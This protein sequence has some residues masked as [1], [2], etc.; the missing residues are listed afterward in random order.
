[1]ILYSDEVGFAPLQH[2]TRKTQAV[3]W[4]FAEFG[5]SMLSCEKV[6]FIMAGI[7]SDLIVDLEDGMSHLFKKLLHF[8][9]DDNG[10]H[11]TRAG[12][13]LQLPRDAYSPEVMMTVI[14]FAKLSII[15]SDEKALKDTF[16]C[17]GASGAKPCMECTNATAI[18]SE[19]SD[20]SEFA[21]AVNHLELA[22]FKPATDASVL[23]SVRRV[24]KAHD[25]HAAGII[26]KAKYEM[27]Q[28]IHGYSYARHNMLLDAS[29]AIGAI[30]V[31]M[32]DWMHVYLVSGMF[33]VEVFQLWTFLQ[34]FGES[35][36]K[37][38]TFFQQWTWPRTVKGC[39]N[40]F[41][42]KN[43]TE[44]KNTDHFKTSA[45]GSLGAYAVIALY[46]QRFVVRTGH[47][48]AQVASFLLLCDVL[49]LCQSL[50]NCTVTADL[51]SH[52][53][54]KHLRAYAAAYGALGFRFK[55]HMAMHLAGQLRR[56]GFLLSCF[57]QERRHKAIKR[58]VNDR[59][60]TLSFESG[61][62]EEVTI[63][64]LYD[65]RKDPG[66]AEMEEPRTPTA[67]QARDLQALW[68]RAP[69]AD[70][71]CARVAMTAGANYAAGDVALFSYHGRA[72]VGQIWYHSGV[73]CS[74]CY[75]T[76]A[77]W[78][79]RVG[80]ADTP[81]AHTYLVRD[82]RVTV[83]TSALT[84]SLIYLRSKDGTAATVLI[85]AMHRS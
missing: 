70:I 44:D 36:L 84:A 48:A 77:L 42:P 1:M 51:L 21:V 56:F 20:H 27:Y 24:H 83:R 79:R 64:H 73:G 53:I 45:S 69:A 13:S 4:S 78:E 61:L 33:N 40:M 68:P 65:L 14:I 63:Q 47:A 57:V 81:Y 67:D 85:P 6:W 5:V 10:H 29:L 75:T 34:P 3:Y 60:N 8:F 71:L 30:S 76:L 50:K 62:M 31:L 39:K 52:V 7:R 46:L 2:D 25:D 22:D 32:F 72:C 9:F 11:F 16:H 82:A 43:I 38:H 54:M 59:K 41:D 74:E 35:W 49:D 28:R 55:H 23:H 26:S 66:H 37:L 58:Y 18:G 19:L 17:K 12:C 80:A 15:V